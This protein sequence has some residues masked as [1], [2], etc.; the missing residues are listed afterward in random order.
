MDSQVGTSNVQTGKQAVDSAA[1]QKKSNTVGKQTTSRGTL[2][3]KQNN[4][5][6]E[7]S[8]LKIMTA[9]MKN[10]DPSS[11]QDNT[12]YVTQMAQFA[13]MQQ[14]NALNSTMRTSSYQGLIGKGVTVDVSDVNGDPYTGIV[15]GVTKENNEWYLS[16]EVEEKGKKIYKVFDA[17]TLKSVLGTSDYTNQN[18]LLNSD[19]MAASNLASD[20]ANKV[21]ILDTDATGTQSIVKGTVKKSVS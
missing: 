10:M 16:V 3:T 17:S 4:E 12:Q 8:F 6:D 19:F 21:V 5:F 18:M 20:S 2:I 1:A 14:M 13:T 11:S 9:Q 7:K 15:R